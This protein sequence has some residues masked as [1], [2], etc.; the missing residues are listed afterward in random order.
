MVLVLVFVFSLF[1]AT[2]PS[3]WDLSS[4][5]RD[6]THAPV[7]EA[8]SLSHQST[9][10]SLGFLGSFEKCFKG[11][12]RDPGWGGEVQ[13]PIDLVQGLTGSLMEAFFFLIALFIY[14]WL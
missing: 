8:K 1:L 13:G 9:R 5:T 7:V 10:K 2:L 6:Q 12:S 3:N 4:P 11:E 14:L